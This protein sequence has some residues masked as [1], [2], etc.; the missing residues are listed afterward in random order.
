M[1]Q[2]RLGAKDDEGIGT[3]AGD[4]G[5]WDKLQLGW[6]DYEVVAAGQTART[7]DLGPQE[8]NTAK[9]AGASSCVLPKKTVDH[10]ARR[11]V[12]GRQAVVV[13]GDGDDLRQHA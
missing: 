13:S 4:L 8:Y 10:R 6:L 9:A 12:R 7:L 2:S 11:A 1:A 5:A 3:R